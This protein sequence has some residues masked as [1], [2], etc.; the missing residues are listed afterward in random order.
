M[1]ICL[2][3]KR[4]IPRSCPRPNCHTPSALSLLAGGELGGRA[5]RRKESPQCAHCPTLPNSSLRAHSLNSPEGSRE[6]GAG[7]GPKGTLRAPQELSSPKSQILKQQKKRLSEAVGL[8]GGGKSG[9]PAGRQVGAGQKPAQ[10]DSRHRP[11]SY[12]GPSSASAKSTAQPRKP[13][14]VRKQTPFP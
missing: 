1:A 13:P 6:R 7:L 11:S 3:L 10:L 4:E 9:E 14:S 8:E 2:A 5:R 12:P